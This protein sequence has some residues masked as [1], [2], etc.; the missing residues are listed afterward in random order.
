VLAVVH[1]ADHDRTDGR[2]HLD[3]VKTGLGCSLACLFE[4]NDADLLTT[5]TDEADGAQTDLVV[6]ANFVFDSGS[7]P[8]L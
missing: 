7:P 2:S 1:D 5:G 3:E 6:D 4:G 8:L